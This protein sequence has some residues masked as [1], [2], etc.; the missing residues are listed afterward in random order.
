[1][2]I[3]RGREG[4]DRRVRVF[5]DTFALTGRSGNARWQD[6]GG[7]TDLVQDWNFA[8]ARL[9]VSI[10]KYPLNVQ[11]GTTFSVVSRKQPKMLKQE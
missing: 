5:L 8:T 3:V 10:E 4:R 6:G 11:A 2:T 9:K 7:R 1:M